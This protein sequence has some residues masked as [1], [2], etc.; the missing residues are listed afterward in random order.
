M[1]IQSDMLRL[2]LAICIAML[3]ECLWLQGESPSNDTSIAQIQ[4]EPGEMVR[5]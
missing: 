3:G 1:L 2:L 4:S 5:R